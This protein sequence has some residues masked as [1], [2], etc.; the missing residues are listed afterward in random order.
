MTPGL[1]WTAI[2]AFALL[3]GGVVFNMLVLQDE[4]VTSAASK[5]QAARAAQKARSDRQRRLALDAAAAPPVLHLASSPKTRAEASRTPSAAPPPSAA[6]PSDR[7]SGVASRIARLAQESARLDTPLAEPGAGA[8]SVE[9][10]KAVQRELVRKGYD[11]GAQDGVPS[12]PT[13]AAILAFEWDHGLALSAE[14]TEALLQNILLDRRA[15][16]LAGAGAQQRSRQ[17]VQVI[18]TIQQSLVVLGYLQGGVDGHLGEATRRAIREFEM[19]NGLVP[20]GRISSPLVAKLAR[21][22][23]AG[24]LSSAR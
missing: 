24:R 1:S 12:L 13:R 17:A 2:C 16:G 10:V 6:M 8:A 7:L 19:D 20:S 15:P 23:A 3:G 21:S 22:A 5:A 11:P 14:P 9:I 4:A 18:R